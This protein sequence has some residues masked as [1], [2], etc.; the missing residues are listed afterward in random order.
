M[1]WFDIYKDLFN[2]IV[3]TLV[4]IGTIALACIAII[5]IKQSLKEKRKQKLDDVVEWA[6]NIRVWQPFSL[7]N[8]KVLK[9]SKN[10]TETWVIS[11]MILSQ[12]IDKADEFILKGISLNAT[13]DKREYKW[14]IYTIWGRMSIVDTKPLFTMPLIRHN[15]F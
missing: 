2:V 11:S 14:L 15:I 1:I 5:E 3:N 10:I 4:A 6:T 13:L 7:E 9:E 8:N 12:V